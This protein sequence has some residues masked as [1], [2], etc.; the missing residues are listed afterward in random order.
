[1]QNM[2]ECDEKCECWNAVIET[3]QND[4]SR[5]GVMNLFDHT[6]RWSAELILGVREAA[7]TLGFVKRGWKVLWYALSWDIM[8]GRGAN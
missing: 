6:G 5:Y 4:V 2:G 1:M 7:V 3:M 8:P